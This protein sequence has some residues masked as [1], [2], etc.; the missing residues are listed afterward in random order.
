V[1]YT[2]DPSTWKERQAEFLRDEVETILAFL[3][4]TVG[5][6]DIVREGVT[7][8]RRSLS[9]EGA[10][11]RSWSL[12]PMIVCEALCGDYRHALP[13]AAALRLLTA[14]AEVFDDIEDADSS[15]SLSARYGAPLATNA[16]TTL[17]ILAERAIARLKTRGVEDSIIVRVMD[18]VNSFY[19]AAC[20]GQHLDLSLTSEMAVSEESYL[21]IAGMKSASTA[22]CACYIGALL[23]NANSELVDILGKF[24]HNL[25]MA[26]Q[27]ANDIQGITVGNDIVKGKTTLPIIY[28]LAQADQETCD[29]LKIP[30]SRQ[31]ETTPDPTQETR[32][33]SISEMGHF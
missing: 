12:L 33:L 16:A 31:S 2:S 9:G 6:Y 1:S 15:S 18:S 7:Q 14:A 8:G 13:V 27:I 22:E 3:S 21:R 5:L 25:G 30:L 24:G 17:L 28:A 23:A 20:A 10:Y 11:D 19:T 4:G 26:S 29:Q 32:V